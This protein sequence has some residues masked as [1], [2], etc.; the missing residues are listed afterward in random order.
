MPT[1]LFYLNSR[2]VYLL[3]SGVC[4]VFS[5]PEQKLRVSYC[6]HPLSVIRPSSEV[7]VMDFDEYAKVSG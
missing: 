1:G 4:L 2:Q 3:Y 5:S 7:K 6:D